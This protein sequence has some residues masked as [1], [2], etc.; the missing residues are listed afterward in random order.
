MS[1][2]II[3]NGDIEILAEIN[4]SPLA[5]YGY[6]RYEPQVESLGFKIIGSSGELKYS[7][8]YKLDYKKGN[9]VLNLGIISF[10]SDNAENILRTSFK[11]YDF[12]LT[13]I[14]TNINDSN[15]EEDNKEP[16]INDIPEPNKN[17]EPKVPDASKND[18]NDV[19]PE[20]NKKIL[21]NAKKFIGSQNWIE[22]VERISFDNKVKL[23]D[24]EP[25]CS[26][27]VYEMLEM[28]GIHMDL[29]NTYGRIHK[30][31]DY[32]QR[33]YVCKQWYKEEVKNFICIGKGVKALNQCLPGDIITNGKHIGI[34]SGPNQ[35]ISAAYIQNKVVENDFGWRKSEKYKVKIFRYQP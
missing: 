31:P 19:I 24:G 10:T 20:M 28:S 6:K 13:K 29:P 22:G 34:I 7:N 4:L 1:I 35:T 2:A 27:F 14:N 15:K 9:G 30:T 25:K 21:E 32:P 16:P 12:I 17:G 5:L 26:L 33:P 11:N 18:N 3:K 23:L 8:Q